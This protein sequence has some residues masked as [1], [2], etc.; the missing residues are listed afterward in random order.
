MNGQQMKETSMKST[1]PGGSMKVI[2]R[3]KF[4]GPEELLITDMPAP[5]PKPGHV[6]IE[7][8]AFGLNHAE[9]HMRRGDWPEAADVSGIE[10]AGIVRSDPSGKLP[11]GQKV[12]ALMGG[13]GRTISGSYAELTNVPATN[14]ARVETKLTWELLA[15]LPE[16]YATAWSCLHGNLGLRPG[17]TIVVRGAT[18]ALGQA[19][20]NIANEADAHVVATSRSQE[21]FAMLATLGARR[22]LVEGPELSRR[23]REHYP[24]GVDGVVDLVGTSTVLDSLLSVRRSG[25]VCLAGGL[26]GFEP[27]V[28]FNPVFQMPCQAHLSIFASFMFGAPAF[29]L[30]DVPLQTIVE[31]AE[32]GLYKARPARVF[33][34]EDIQEAHRLMESNKAEGKV[35]VLGPAAS[36]LV[37]LG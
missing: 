15:A 24:Q 22:T 21:R 20:V 13:M 7:V 5:E 18:S 27:L 8:K 16:S 19:L 33:A 26:G 10:C 17:Q 14:V 36:P 12:V 6:L 30:A 2:A 34:F 11:P 35:V 25:R 31:K 4:G 23:L 28:A 9:L 37:P 3:V 1:T 32:A 29:P